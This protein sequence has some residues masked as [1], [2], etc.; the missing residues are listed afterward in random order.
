M[1]MGGCV[2]AAAEDRASLDER[3]SVML[4]AAIDIDKHAFQAVALDPES[5][6]VTGERRPHRSRGTQRPELDE[7]LQAPCFL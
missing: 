5:G 3:R 1:F 2:L 6:E 7:I 4:Y